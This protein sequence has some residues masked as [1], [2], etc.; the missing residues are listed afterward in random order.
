MGEGRSGE[1]RVGQKQMAG[2]WAKVERSD[3][4]EV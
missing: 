3:L 4:A 2:W 1:D